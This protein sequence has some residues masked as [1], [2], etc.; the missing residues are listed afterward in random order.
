MKISIW[1]LSQPWQLPFYLEPVYRNASSSWCSVSPLHTFKHL[2]EL[3]HKLI[4]CK[5]STQTNPIVARIETKAGHG[6][7]KPTSKIIEEVAD[8]WAFA[9]AATSSAL[10]R[11][12]TAVV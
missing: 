8:M 12:G 10:T 3:Q 1:G 9:A 2:A 11:D 5:G 4:K 7:G 6:A